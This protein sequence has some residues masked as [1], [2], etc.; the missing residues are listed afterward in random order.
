MPLKSALII[1]HLIKKQQGAGMI[2]VMVSLLILAVGLLGVLSLQ[3]NGLNS[4][5]RAEFV[6]QAQILAQ[7]M[8]DRIL[9]Y[10]S[11]ETNGNRG[12]MTGQYGATDTSSPVTDPDCENPITGGGCDPLN[13]VTF[14]Q[15]EWQQLF[16]GPDISLPSGRGTVTWAAP[17]YTITIYWDQDR[18]G[19]TGTNCNSRDKSATGNLTCFRMEVRP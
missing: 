1:S 6:S 5:Q 17:I 8:A 3:A 11:L 2:E 9:A 19:A 12:A 18:T 15:A 16:S 13:T 10:G 7:D 14:D 4:N